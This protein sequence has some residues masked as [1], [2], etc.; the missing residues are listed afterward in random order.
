MLKLVLLIVGA[1][2]YLFL[3]L[4]M[5]WSKFFVNFYRVHKELE[6]ENWDNKVPM[7][8]HVKM[9]IEKMEQERTWFDNDFLVILFWPLYL[10]YVKK[11]HLSD[12][13][14]ALVEVSRERDIYGR[15]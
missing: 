5:L 12:L 7:E 15:D 6:P 11:H 4:L 13:K 1:L 10:L 8:E 14:E 3:G 9:V 2:A